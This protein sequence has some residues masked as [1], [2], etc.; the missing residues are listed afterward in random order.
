LAT[1]TIAQNVFRI[2]VHVLRQ[3]S[4]HSKSR[5]LD[6]ADNKMRWLRG[7]AVARGSVVLRLHRMPLLEKMGKS[8]A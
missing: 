6:I 1:T 7:S 5:F 3:H 4:S 8:E 2:S